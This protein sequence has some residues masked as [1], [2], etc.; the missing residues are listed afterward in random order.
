VWIA[1][2][3]VPANGVESKR[4]TVADLLANMDKKRDT[5]SKSEAWIEKYIKDENEGGAKASAK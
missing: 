5:G 3:D 2:A 4:P 1:K